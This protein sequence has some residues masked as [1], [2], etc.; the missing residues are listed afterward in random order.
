LTQL[1]E[2]ESR[3]HEL[4][5]HG[6]IN[7]AEDAQSLPAHLSALA[8]G[9]PDYELRSAARE[10]KEHN[11]SVPLLAA[12]FEPIA[13]SFA[14]EKQSASSISALDENF[15]WQA[16]GTVIGVASR[17]NEERTIQA[18]FWIPSEWRIA[19]HR[20]KMPL[21]L[22]L[23]YPL[24]LEEEFEFTLPGEAQQI[25]LPG[26]EEN[27]T[28]PLRWKIEWVR[29]GHDKLAARLHVEL[30]RGELSDAQT[31]AFQQQLPKLL[32]TLAANARWSAH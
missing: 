2:A 4:K 32:S 25:R 10:A 14:L 31:A 27:N 13:G 24:T 30:V 26:V 18:P 28:E 23:G 9:C 21:F 1:P 20:R 29:V 22:N 19:L 15:S 8:V 11:G 6:E 16:T 7:C 5:L 12:R 3:D 17:V